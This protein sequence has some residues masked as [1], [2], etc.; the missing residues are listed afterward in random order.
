M[1]KEELLAAFAKLSPKEQWELADEL[2]RSL[3][4]DPGDGIERA[5]VEEAERRYDDF[6]AG[7]QSAAGWEDVLRRIESRR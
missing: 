4:G 2:W 5:Q 3:P 7:R 1:T 6:L